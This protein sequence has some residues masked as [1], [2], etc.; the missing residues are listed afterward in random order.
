MRMMIFNT[1][2]NLFEVSNNS[3]YGADA[4]EPDTGWLPGGE[5]RTLG[6][7]SGKPEPWYEQLEFEQVDFPIASYIFGSKKEDRK[8]IALVSKRIPVGNLKDAL[9]SLD[10]E[11]DE[12]KKNTESM[13]RE[14]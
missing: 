5:A 3:G 1:M 7:E 14:V 9:K 4:G 11:I 2:K 13:Y 10:V 12:L 8:R 6:F